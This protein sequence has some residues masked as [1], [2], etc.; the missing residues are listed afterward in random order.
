MYIIGQSAGDASL[1]Q[2]GIPDAAEHDLIR[3]KEVEPGYLVT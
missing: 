3:G 2:G 1:A